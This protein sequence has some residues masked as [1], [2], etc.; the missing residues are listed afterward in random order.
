MLLWKNKG[1]SDQ[2][3]SVLI[4]AKPQWLTLMFFGKRS[5][6]SS[7]CGHV[8]LISAKWE[9]PDR[10]HDLFWVGTSQ[11]LFTKETLYT[12][13]T[14]AV[15]WGETRG[16]L[17]WGWKT[18]ASGQVEPPQ[19]GVLNWGSPGRF[20]QDNLSRPQPLLCIFVFWILHDLNF[21]F[22]FFSYPVPAIS[23][24]SRVKVTVKV[25][26]LCP[27]LYKPMDYTDH[28]ILQAR[29]LEWV[30]FPF[31]RGSSQSGGWTQVSYIAGGF[32][33]SWDTREAQEYWS[34]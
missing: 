8:H 7:V 17:T 29:I 20:V 2:P 4:S 1:K 23:L 32:F 9:S 14:C 24:W 15:R 18:P 31:F 3:F 27:T 19:K 13:L 22:F 34:G 6:G 10:N 26:Q 21:V 11:N 28:G 5:F 30:A 16:R 33:T 25:P 12:V